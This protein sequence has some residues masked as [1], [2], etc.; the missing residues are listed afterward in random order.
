VVKNGVGH[1]L[2]D[3]SKAAAGGIVMN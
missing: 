2:A 3:P 1:F